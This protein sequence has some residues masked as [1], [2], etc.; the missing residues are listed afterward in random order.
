M[1]DDRRGVT[2]FNME[3]E[4]DEGHFDDKGNFVW[5]DEAK[6]VQEEA[7]L[8]D[9]SEQQIGAAK[10]AKSRRNFRDQQGEETMTTEAAN[11]TLAKLLKP[12]ETALQALKRL[13]SKKNARVRAGNKRKQAQ[14]AEDTRTEQEKQQFEQVTE[15][16]DF[17]MR[18]G[19]VDV[20][21]QIKEEFIPEEELL[22]QRQRVQF[23]EQEEGKS[24]EEPPKEEIMWE[25][26]ATDGQIHGPY[27]TSSFVAW[28]QQGY[29]KG[30][31][32]V[33]MRQVR[34]SNDTT[35]EPKQ[36]S[37]KRQKLEP[38]KVSAEQEML[39]DFDDF[40]EEEDAPE[41]NGENEADDNPWKR[42]DLIDFSSY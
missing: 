14:R 37:N 29:F 33:D 32:A 35:E 4:K 28:Q 27:P 36:G 30:E 16:A 2:A 26:K 15:A 34:S 3:D 18:S 20:Y 1:A 21:S 24:E 13:G 7:W 8:D 5:D 40:D 31:S 42:S 39:D 19:E 11:E 17:L 6:K 23:A 25:Y 10:S 41:V 9:V 38:A 12:R 22:A